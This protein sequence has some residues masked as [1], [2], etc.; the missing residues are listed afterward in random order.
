MDAQQDSLKHKG[1]MGILSPGTHFVIDKEGVV[2]E[3]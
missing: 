3:R 1:W 2:Q